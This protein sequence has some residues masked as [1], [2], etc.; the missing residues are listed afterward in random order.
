M[1]E[2]QTA[3]RAPV[4]YFLATRSGMEWMDPRLTDRG[5]RPETPREIPFRPCRRIEEATVFRSTPVP[6]RASAAR[7]RGAQ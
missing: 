1:S 4:S 5:Y 7:I 3:S 2:I 6:F